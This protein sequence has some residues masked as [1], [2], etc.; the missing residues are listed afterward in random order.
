MAKVVE[1]PAFAERNKRAG[2]QYVR[3]ADGVELPVIDVSHPAFALSLSDSEQKAL[4]DKFLEEGAPLSKLPR[5]LRNLFLRFLLRGSILARGIGQAQ[6]T[7]LSAMNTYLLKLGPDMLGAYAKPIDRRIAGALPALAVRLRLQDMAQLMADTLVRP[8]S[9][10]PLRPLTFLNIAGGTAIDS[11][12]ALILLQKNQPG[13]LAQRPVFIEVLDLEEIAP[14]FG[15][16]ALAALLAEGAPLHGARIA[17]RHIRYD[18]SQASDLEP[19][20]SEARAQGAVI[21]G[22]FEGGLFE[23]GSDDEIESSLKVLRSAPEVLAVVGSVTRSDEPIRQLHATSR[24]ATRPRGLPVFRE[25]ARKA[26][27]NIVRVIERPFSD[28]VV[29]T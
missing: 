10:D 15:E 23:Y 4:I 25:L 13:I 2:I 7:F 1:E 19:V 21:I 26:G 5:F 16:D 14:K 24:A 27:W 28:Q 11:L 3:T 9:D 18:W 29:L 20:L 6:N 22:C 12:N 8:L 17:F